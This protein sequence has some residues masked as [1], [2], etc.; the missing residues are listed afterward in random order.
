MAEQDGKRCERSG[1][2]HQGRGK[3]GC[4]D[5]GGMDGDGGEAEAAGRLLQEGA[6]ATVGLDQMRLAAREE[7]EHEAWKASTGAQ[8]DQGAGLRWQQGEK[9]RRIEDVALPEQLGLGSRHEVD[10]RVPANEKG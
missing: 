9:L 8:I 2:Q 4:L 7:G 10:A 1:S 3:L 6:F 5:S